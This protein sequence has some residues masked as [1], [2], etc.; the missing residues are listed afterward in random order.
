MSKAKTTPT[1]PPT[2][3]TGPK[4]GWTRWLAI[5]GTQSISTERGIYVAVDGYIDLPDGE[6]KE[7]QGH[8][9]S[10]APEAE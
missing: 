10:A 7:M 2:E 1:P 5:N 9:Y 3:P 8:L 6:L 4:P